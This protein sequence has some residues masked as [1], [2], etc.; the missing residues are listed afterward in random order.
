VRFLAIRKLGNAASLGD[1]SLE[2]DPEDREIGGQPGNRGATICEQPPEV[3]MNWRRSKESAG[4]AVR[5]SAGI[6]QRQ[7]PGLDNRYGRRKLTL[8]RLTKSSEAKPWRERSIV[9]LR[10]IVRQRGRVLL[11]S[12]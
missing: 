4:G 10:A 7:T 9:G 8:V 12:T 5:R 6:K 2:A 1:S 3:G 11:K